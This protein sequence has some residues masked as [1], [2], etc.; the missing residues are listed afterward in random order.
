MAK[1]EKI[2][3]LCL[4]RGIIFPT[5]EIYGS[6]AGFFEYGEI[7]LRI[8]RKLEDLWRMYLASDPYL[9]IIEIYGSIVLPEPVLVASGHVKGFVDPITQCKKCHTIFRADHLIEEKAGLFVEGKS[10]EE[11]TKIIRKKNIRCPKCGGE[12]DDVKVFNLMLQTNIGPV[13]G[14]TA[15]LRPETAQNIFIDFKRIFNTYRGK[16]PFGIAQIGFAFRN[17]ISPRNFLI[18][19]RAFHQAEI[20]VFF[21]PKDDKCPIEKVKDVKIPFVSR[22]CQ[23]SGKEKIEWK[24]ID[25]LL[26]EGIIKAKWQAYYLAKEYEFFTKV[27]GIPK[28][29]LRFRYALEE[30]TP[31]YSK[32]NF[33]L[34]VYMDELKWKEVIGNA[35]RTDYDLSTH[36]KCSGEDLSITTD[37]G[38][39]II[40]HVVEPSLGIE[41]TLLSILWYSFKEKG[42][43][44]GWNWLKLPYHLSP[45]LVAVFPLLSNKEELV[46]KAREVFETLR[47]EFGNDVLYDE[48]GSIGKRYARVDEIGV[49]FAITID[50]Q[51]LEDNTVTIRFRDTK[52]QE[53][54]AIDKIVEKINSLVEIRI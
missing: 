6:L 47:K 27:L 36:S 20:E 43:D 32:G 13:S 45:Y 14:N 50:H 9:R 8:K 29:K 4:K 12:L 46:S 54:I 2:I 40:P 21:D 52:T 41:R 1:L 10:V 17:E 3:N 44:R 11:M 35:Y 48:K 23:L 51:T 7:G 28:E 31:F 49:P 39:K 25:E 37:N 30:E 22:E 15:Y 19:M 24:S 42:E 33:D 34:E 53:R 5:A 16:L 26:K 18:R 38:R